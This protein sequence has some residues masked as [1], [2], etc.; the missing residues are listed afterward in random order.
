MNEKMAVLRTSPNSWEPM[1]GTTVRSRPTI[2]PTKAF[3]RT[4]SE[5]CC[6]FSLSPRRMCVGGTPRDTKG[7]S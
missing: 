7:P 3:T 1:R 2:P 4:S 6:Q 5:N